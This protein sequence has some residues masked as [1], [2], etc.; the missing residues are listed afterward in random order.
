MRKTFIMLGMLAALT[1]L[2][3]L[4]SSALCVQ[5]GKANLRSGPGTGFEKV[6]QVYK[7]MPLKQVGTSLSGDWY[8]VMDVD[9]DVSWIF[10]P[11]V[12]SQY[13]CAVVKTAVVNIRSGPGTKYR[14]KFSEP[15]KRY[16]SFLILESKG[17]WH[18]VKDA[19]GNVGWIHK[20]YLWSD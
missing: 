9:G 4:S 20:D 3:P 18:K 15:A 11:L 12:T 10:K 16:D 13:P 19:W 14:K 7:Y 17:A 8:A 1:V 2:L 6:W 5:A